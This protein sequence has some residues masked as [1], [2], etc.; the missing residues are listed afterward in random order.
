MQTAEDSVATDGGK[1]GDRKVAGFDLRTHLK[2]TLGAEDKRR[3][4]EEILELQILIEAQMARRLT[5]EQLVPCGLE[6]PAAQ[7]RQLLRW[8]R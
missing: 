6:L 8:L 7:R 5:A 4:D 2:G 3:L 1:R